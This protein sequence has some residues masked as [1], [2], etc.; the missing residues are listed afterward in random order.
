MS[1]KRIAALALTAAVMLFAM[2]PHAFAFEAEEKKDPASF[3][4]PVPDGLPEIDVDR[5][6]L[7]LANSYNGI[8]TYA[9]ENHGG[10][11]AIWGTGIATSIYE[12]TVNFIQSAQSAGYS[13]WAADGHKSWEYFLSGDTIGKVASSGSARDLYGTYLPAGCNEH[14]T[15]L[16]IDVEGDWEGI[17][18]MKEHC[19]EF[20]FI[21]RY[22]DGKEQYYGTPCPA[23]N[24]FRYVGTEAAEYITENGLCLEEFLLMYGVP[25]NFAP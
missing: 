14:Q 22:P 4:Y 13:V 3:K 5:G 18:Y 23:E 12:P 17:Q 8:G 16:A 1:R 20:G 11:S 25:V 15:G 19:A 24:H 10:V 21:Y 6:F 9:C 7:I 2:I